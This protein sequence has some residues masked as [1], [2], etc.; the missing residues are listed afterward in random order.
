[1]Q[2]ILLLGWLIDQ[3]SFTPNQGTWF[4]IVIGIAGLLV[5]MGLNL[6]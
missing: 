6:D 2:Y 5:R 3:N 1:M 4:I